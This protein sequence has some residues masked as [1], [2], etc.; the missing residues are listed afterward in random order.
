MQR[1]DQN[2]FI[3]S[4]LQ[5]TRTDDRPGPQIEWQLFL[6]LNFTTQ[7]LLALSRNH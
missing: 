4:H 3:L 5:E 7:N 2:M 6:V 1:D